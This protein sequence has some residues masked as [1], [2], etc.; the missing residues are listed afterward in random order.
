MR[1]LF[2]VEVDGT[3][4]MPVPAERL[5]EMSRL[6]TEQYRREADVG[7]AMAGVRRN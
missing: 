6:R 4:L 7:M 1:K 5:F 2:Y 3:S